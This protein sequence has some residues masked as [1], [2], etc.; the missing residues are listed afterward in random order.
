MGQNDHIWV[1]MTIFGS[2][3]GVWSWKQGFWP[4]LL[5]RWPIWVQKWS[6]NSSYL[7]PKWV[8]IDLFWV[9]LDPFWVVLDPFLGP[10]LT[11]FE[12]KWLKMAQNLIAPWDLVIWGVPEMGHFGPSK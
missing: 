12:R 5:S 10:F 3:L 2:Y 6:Q 1:K 11:T 4:S 8:K 7:T 9:I